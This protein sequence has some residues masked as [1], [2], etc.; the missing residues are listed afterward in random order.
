MAMNACDE[1]VEKLALFGHNIGMAFQIVDDVFDITA[2]EGRIGKPVGNDIREGD[3]TLPMLRAMQVCNEADKADLKRVIGAAIN[4][5]AA[6]EESEVQ[7][8]LDILRGCDA[9][10]YS[11][12]LARQYIVS[13]KTQLE[14]FP[15][16]PARSMLLDIADYVTSREK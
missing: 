7:H 11:L 3:I 13:A 8:A 9:V 12:D 6:I 16:V 4:K 10:E 1:D 2:T 15:D 14:S 5:D